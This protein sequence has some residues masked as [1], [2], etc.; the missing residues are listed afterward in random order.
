MYPM[1][2]LCINRIICGLGQ[3]WL[4]T[5]TVKLSI[6]Q[7]ISTCGIDPS[8]LFKDLLRGFFRNVNVVVFAPNWSLKVIN[9]A[10]IVTHFGAS[11]VDQDW[12][13]IIRLSSYRFIAFL[14]RLLYVLNSPFILY[15]FFFN[16]NRI[17]LQG[18]DKLAWNLL[19]KIWKD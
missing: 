7:I 15:F 19:L 17:S 14:Y 3:M 8:G 6:N 4:N 13:Q 16:L 1:H 11:F 10:V 5:N 18:F 9:V 12:V 2:V